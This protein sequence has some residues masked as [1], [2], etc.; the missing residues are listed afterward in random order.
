[1]NE[2]ECNYCAESNE[3]LF[4]IDGE[5]SG[6]ILS[7]ADCLKALKEIKSILSIISEEN[8]YFNS[9]FRHIRK[10]CR[11]LEIELAS[12]RLIHHEVGDAP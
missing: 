11:S 12:L 3:N 4:V 9:A 10:A 5:F 7:I 2:C 6:R 8:E 1:M